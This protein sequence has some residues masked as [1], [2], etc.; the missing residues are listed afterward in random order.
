M[1]VKD[2]EISSLQRPK[3][4]PRALFM[5]SMSEGCLTGKNNTEDHTGRINHPPLLNT[6]Q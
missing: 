4:R 1:N 5:L 3:D 6:D 2:S